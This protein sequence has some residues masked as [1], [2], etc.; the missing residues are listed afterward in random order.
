MFAPAL[1]AALSFSRAFM[2]ATLAALLFIRA[3]QNLGAVCRAA[4]IPG[5][6]PAFSESHNSYSSHPT[7]RKEGV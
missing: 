2:T 6:L 7:L 3:G 4:F 1:V 5:N